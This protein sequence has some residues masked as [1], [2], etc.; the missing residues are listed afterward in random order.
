MWLREQAVQA[1]GELP[2]VLEAVGGQYSSF[3]RVSA[4]TGLPTVLGWPGHEWQ[5]RGG[6]H[7]EPG[8]R[9]PLVRQIYS[10]P[11]LELVAFMLDELDVAYIYVGDLETR[12]YEAAGLAKFR[13]RLE[14]AFANDGVTIYRWQPAQRS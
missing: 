11:D 10:T 6:D 7:P 2:V 4:N 13:D 1:G 3:G 14:I 5:W 9:E 8:R 12:T